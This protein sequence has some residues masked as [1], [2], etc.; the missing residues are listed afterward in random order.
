MHRYHRRAVLLVLRCDV[1]F[2]V[3]LHFGCLSYFSFFFQIALLVQPSLLFVFCPGLS[4][5][6]SPQRRY[7]QGHREGSQRW[8]V[9]HQFRAQGIRKMEIRRH[10]SLPNR[11]LNIVRIALAL[12]FFCLA[13]LQG[14]SRNAHFVNMHLRSHAFMTET[15]R[16][17]DPTT[18][19]NDPQR[20][21]GP[22]CRE[23]LVSC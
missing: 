17:D 12:R 13:R 15:A 1:S 10:I 11:L 23:C 4:V 16:R 7:F 18:P 3:L 21:L 14:L 22:W 6:R 20:A 8:V 2:Q 19:N 9:S 5:S